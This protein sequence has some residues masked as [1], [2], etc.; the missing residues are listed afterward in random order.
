MV[1]GIGLAILLAAVITAGNASGREVNVAVDTS[2]TYQTIEGFGT[3]WTY[4]A[5]LPQY[6]DP[7]FFDMVV[8]DL[9]V[10]LVR[11]EIPGDL[12]AVNDDEDPSHFNWSA[13]NVS[14]MDRLMRFCQEFKKRGVSRFL[15]DTFS[16][17]A[18]LKT[19]RAHEW[20]GYLR[21]DMWDEYA[22]FMTAFIILARKNW[23]INITDI[24]IQNELLFIEWYSSCV[25]HPQAAREAV[26]ALMRRFKGDGVGTR[27][28]MPEDMMTYDRMMRYI[29]PTMEDPE[30]KE[31]PGHFCTHRLGGFDEVRRFY[32]DTRQYNR[33]LWMTET[34]GHPQNW[35]GAMKMA[36]DIYDY[37]VGG[38][39]SVWV[40]LR[41]TVPSGGGGLMVDG[42][43]AP[44]YYAAKHWYRYVRPGALR[45]DA[46]S[47]EDDL[48]VAAFRH[49][50]DGTLTVVL[51]NR[52]DQD[53]AV[54]LT[55]P[56]RGL[57]SNYTLY[58][59][60]ESEGCQD[61]GQVGAAPEFTMPPKSIVTLYGESDALKTRAALEPIPVG[62]VDPNPGDGGRWGE[63]SPI[64]TPAIVSAAGRGASAQRIR[65]E[66]TRGGDVN[67]ADARGWTAL[68]MAIHHGNQNNVIPLLME[69]GA[70]VN[71]PANDGWTPLHVAAGSF[72]E[73]RYPIFRQIMAA[74][75]DVNAR[76]EDGWTPLHS[77]VAGAYVAWRQSES[78]TLNRVRDLIEAGANVE[79]KDV[80][81]RTPLHWAAMQGYSM[82]LNV[83][84]GVARVLLDAG[85]DLHAK[86]K[87]GRTPLHYA[88][89]QGYD[90]IV[91]ALVEAGARADAKDG[92]N[93]TPVDLA[94]ERGLR[95]TVKILLADEDTA[96][97]PTVR[98]RGSGKLGAELLRA[99][100]RGDM[101]EV[102]SLLDQGADVFYRDSD[103]FRP[104][105]RTRDYGHNEIVKLLK[106][107]EERQGKSQPSGGATPP[108]VLSTVKWDPKKVVF[109]VNCGSQDP[110]L[111][112]DGN[113][114]NADRPF[115]QG[116]YGY[117]GGGYITRENLTTV[118][119][120]KLHDVYRTEHFLL[121]AYRICLPNDKYAVR[122]HWAE[123]YG[124]VYGAQQRQ[125]NVKIEGK[126]VLENLDPFKEAGGHSTAMI[127]TVDVEVKDGELTVEFEPIYESTMINGIEVMRN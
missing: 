94:Q 48:L 52:S 67:T 15:G 78:D 83:R 1:R 43:P 73:K 107:A 126:L 85:A 35:T 22:E 8:N 24:T 82:Q 79:A 12:E 118:K 49:D 45:V 31:F 122:L 61:K 123:T 18:F 56:G 59:S 88:A 3:M 115:E 2:K 60:T 95:G 4:W 91:A 46:Q 106:E 50:V 120:T 89:Q 51:I 11:V 119:G 71:K 96:L 97:E 5:W 70:D 101:A 99:A 20:G 74:S 44:K 40:Y 92:R 111:D 87:L 55:A 108:V 127:K 86:D 112:P 72:H 76:T 10:S 80:N 105:D 75:P 17:G 125:M 37:L 64:R 68:H 21:A 62:W 117:V 33:Q 109:R 77:A 114:W 63:F 84:D 19:N 121:N 53:A 25:Y 124:G 16:P 81:G 57:P 54:H 27:I 28:H 100:T 13:F 103:G 34:S 38:N 69:L 113:V 104:I 7:N 41:L 32:N 65:Q 29:R 116:K 36:S 14:Y 58:R 102:K 6:D 47:T 110:Y 93:A 66:V 98:R 26:R 42:R 39:F 9:G 23:G 90:S 30:T